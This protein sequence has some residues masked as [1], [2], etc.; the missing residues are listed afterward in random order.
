MHRA[1]TA[2]AQPADAARRVQSLLAEFGMTPAARSKVSG[3]PD[4]PGDG[5]A[6]GFFR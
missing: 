1:H 3:L 2:V 5:P 4:L 6:R